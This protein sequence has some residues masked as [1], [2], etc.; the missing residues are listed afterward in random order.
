MDE[1]DKQQ[2]PVHQGM[3]RQDSRASALKWAYQTESTVCQSRENTT[4]PPA[5]VD[6]F[7]QITGSL[8]LRCLAL[9][10]LVGTIIFMATACSSTKQQ[11]QVPE[12]TSSSTVDSSDSPQKETQV[13]AGGKKRSEPTP[14]VKKPAEYNGA[15]FEPTRGFDQSVIRSGPVV[16]KEDRLV[17]RHASKSQTV[18]GDGV[19]LSVKTAARG[20]VKSEGPGYFTGAPFQVFEISLTNNSEHELDLSNVVVTLLLD[21]G[22]K[23][24]LPL[25]GEVEVYDF[26][27]HVSAGK[28]LKTRYAFII[29]KGHQRAELIVDLDSAHAPSVLSVQVARR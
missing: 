18:Y 9:I 12:A 7:T 8:R 4:C 11:T 24:A 23:A 16:E 21:D 13:E 22:K 2:K 25:Y 28:S 10:L 19:S 29:P 14:K 1:A 6:S 26:T 5:A 20:T 15:A 27:G 3:R 17:P